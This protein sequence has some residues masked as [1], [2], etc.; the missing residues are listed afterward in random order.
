[1]KRM[2]SI[3]LAVVLLLAAIPV[4]TVLAECSHPET[5]TKTMDG[6]LYDIDENYHYYPY[7]SWVECTICGKKL[8]EYDTVYKPFS[9]TPD[10]RGRCSE[11]GYL[12]CKHPH[13]SDN[14]MG[15]A[16]YT[17]YDEECHIK[18]TPYAEQCDVCSWVLSDLRDIKEI[19][20][21]DFSNN[22]CF[23]CGYRRSSSSTA[24][25]RPTNTLAPTNTP[26]ICGHANTTHYY[27]ST[28]PPIIVSTTATTHTVQN[29]YKA[30][31]DDCGAETGKTGYFD[32]ATREHTFTNG[33]CLCGYIQPASPTTP[34]PGVCSHTYVIN[35][36]KPVS[37]SGKYTYDSNK[38]TRVSVRYEQYC[39][40]CGAKGP[41]SGDVAD[42]TVG[43]HWFTSGYT[44]GV[45]EHWY[46]DTTCNGQCGYTRYE[47]R[48][49]HTYENGVCTTCGARTQNCQ[50]EMVVEAEPEQV[51]TQ[52]DLDDWMHTGSH[53]VETISYEV[54]KKCGY[55]VKSEEQKLTMPKSHEYEGITCK[56]CGYS[57]TE[58]YFALLASI[59]EGANP[60]DNEMLVDILWIEFTAAGMSRNEIQEICKL[61]EKAPVTYRDLYLYS[62]FDYDIK[63][64]K[65]PS[66]PDANTVYIPC[67]EDPNGTFE[68]DGKTYSVVNSVFIDYAKEGLLPATW[69][70]E[71]GHAL[72]SNYYFDDNLTLW[73]TYLYIGR[74]DAY[75]KMDDDVRSFIF[76]QATS[77][78]HPFLARKWNALT[79]DEQEQIYRS[80][81]GSE[82]GYPEHYDP[83]SDTWTYDRVSLNSELQAIQ[84]ELVGNMIASVSVGSSE[85]RNAYMVTDCLEGMTNG[86][87]SGRENSEARDFADKVWQWWNTSEVVS[88]HMTERQTY[89]HGVD[90]KPTMSQG[91]EAWAE[92]YSA[93]MTGNQDAIN[94]NL[95]YFP[96]TC[97]YFDTLA[98][99]MLTHYQEKARRRR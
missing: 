99:E 25:P 83:S 14:K 89:W 46:T 91:A 98:E 94:S 45:D 30:I 88:G 68:E 50:H 90:G 55:R 93:I 72:E 31:C 75:Q 97:A 28:I 81:I 95:Y 74:E 22:K 59:P 9:H 12:V 10:G 37:G 36:D 52:Y 4:E 49:P 57:K 71:T 61:V 42:N 39:S 79:A 17:Y 26:T 60:M 96:E 54:C 38:H 47:N 20:P 15:P 78:D 5:T 48:E 32:A 86:L 67:K 64:V 82:V 62:F 33:M 84:D 51:I 53:R 6:F 44:H 41:N 34:V 35:T 43:S 24:T 27:D 85:T 16:S 66:D 63:I 87:V 76:R 8:E 23:Y 77:K 70:H 73:G 19:V 2:F 3:L 21:H 56:H 13:T 92:Y 11:C 7:W 65:D 29:G 1:M 40:K 69:F 18:E 58:D 80:I